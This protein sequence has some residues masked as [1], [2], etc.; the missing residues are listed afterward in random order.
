MQ[1]YIDS[2]ILFCGRYRASA[3]AFQYPDRVFAYLDI[4]ADT[5]TRPEGRCHLSE[6]YATKIKDN[7][8]NIKLHFDARIYSR[9]V[10]LHSDYA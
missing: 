8:L 1:S 10:S 9:A 5:E 4:S 2:R 6:K 7:E 3:E